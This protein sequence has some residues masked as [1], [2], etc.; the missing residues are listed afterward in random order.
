MR[1]NYDDP[2][3]KMN[4]LYIGVVAD[5]DDPEGLGRVRVRIPGLIEP[6]SNWAWPLGSSGGGNEDE[7]FFNVPSLDSEV[8]VFF[9]L[10]DPDH[11]YYLPA[12]WGSGEVPEASSSGDPDIKVMA[13][14][15]YD[16][17]VDTRTAT[18]G[19]KIV[20]KAA[21]DNII[22]FNGV[23][24]SMKISSTTSIEISSTGQISI[25]GLIV[26]ING[27]TAGLGQL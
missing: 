3:P 1:P 9:K 15:D 7:G 19:F 24:R 22:E 10:G 5:R 16:I 2:I 6:A 27:I 14:K 26:T 8:G 21:N 18:K 23:T 12:N 4:G 11:P 25:D 17:V 20:D 13:L